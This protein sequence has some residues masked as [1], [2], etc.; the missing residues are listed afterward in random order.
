MKATFHLVLAL[1]FV[2]WCSLFAGTLQPIAPG[3][4]VTEYPRHELQAN[5]KHSFIV[6]VE[7]LG[8]SVG[9]KYIVKSLAP[10]KWNSERNAV[11]RGFLEI[12]ADGDYRFT[13]RSFYDRNLLM[14]DGKI[15]CAFGDGEETVATIPLKKGRVSI[16]SAGFVGGRGASGIE[17]RWQPPGQTELSP[18]PP[19]LLKHPDD[20]TVKPQEKEI[21]KQAPRVAGLIATH[22]IAVADDFVVEAY[23][24][25]ARIQDGRRKLLDEI[26]G[27]TVERMNV[28]MRPG[29]WIVFHVVNNHLRWGGAK[30][31]AVAGCLGSNEFGFVSDPAS[32]NWSVCDD[33][34]RVRDFIRK[35]DEG[36]EIRAGA[37]AKPWEEG[38]DHMRRHAGAGFPGKALWGG[39]GSTWI[40]FVAPPKLEKPIVLPSN[41]I[42][43]VKE[44]IQETAPAKPA[45]KAM[46]NPTRWPVQILYAMYG[47]G[48]R[49]ADVTARLKELVET[50]KT[51]FAVDPPTLGI[52]PIPYWNKSLWIAFIKDGVR[53]EVRR[54]ENEHVLPEYFYG[55]Q[56]APELDKWLP[57]SRWRS[58]K[59]ELQFNADHT[60]TGYGFEGTP[61]WEALANNKLRITWS[62]GRKVEYVFDYTWS[63]FHEVTNDKAVFRVVP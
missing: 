13:T 5:D 63:S 1:G 19:H 35:R 61:T 25:G 16:L 10:W 32:E 54:Y 58:E 51:W 55:P 6:P 18:I 45:P 33:P 20:G 22:L 9:Q 49:N 28:E 42:V 21:P 12:A 2:A 57:A 8:D 7:K 56:D 52:D 59:G 36:T 39:G 23:K 15:V 47:S 30:Y 34:S 37:I 60:A 43:P 50:K 41:E 46:L 24:N 38:D 53:R 44:V 27:A 3:L 29:D 26:H 11:A 31:F 40:K 48:D 62:A 14:I 4:V 17:V